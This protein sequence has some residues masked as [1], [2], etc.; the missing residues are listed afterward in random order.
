MQII[1]NSWWPFLT[2]FGC[3][4]N[5]IIC[6]C[7]YMKLI[8]KLNQCRYSFLL[9]KKNCGKCFNSLYQTTDFIFDFTSINF[10]LPFSFVGANEPRGSPGMFWC[11]I[12]DNFTRTPFKFLNAGKNNNKTLQV[13]V[14][15]VSFSVTGSAGGEDHLAERSPF[16][17]AGLR[18]ES[19]Y[20]RLFVLRAFSSGTN[21]TSRPRGLSPMILWPPARGSY[22][23]PTASP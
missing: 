4:I 7:Q 5:L 16:E 3:G 10:F 6:S 23:S 15:S 20:R 8:L 19:K 12:A 17:G 13:S 1:S 11:P 22:R 18:G 9:K 14:T 21:E 2:L